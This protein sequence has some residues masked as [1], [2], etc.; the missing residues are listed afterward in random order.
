MT[1]GLFRARTLR[2]LLVLIG[3]TS[4]TPLAAQTLQ[5]RMG[6]PIDGLSPAELARFEEG[7]LRFEQFFTEADGLGPVFNDDSC[8]SCHSLP[9]TGGAGVL[10]VNRFGFADKGSPFDP[11]DSQGGTLLQA[12]SISEL[13]AETIPPI[14]NVTAQRITP[15][16][17]GAG[18][19]EAI[20]DT[21]LLALELTGGMAHLVQPL[22]DP[23]GPLRVGRFG[24]KSQVATI[25]TFSGDAALNEMGITNRLVTTENAP[26]GDAALLAMCDTVADPEDLP[27]GQGVEFIDRITDFQRFL[28]PP[29]QTPKTGM[30]G[31][32]VF[33]N[34]GC[35]DCHQPT[36]TTGTAPEAALSNRLIRPYSDFLVHNMGALGD[37]IVDGAANEQ[38]M[39]T[40]SLW[41]VRTRRPL[42]H[43]GRVDA[44]DLETAIDESVGWHSGEGAASAAAY[45]A[46]NATDK[47]ALIAFLDSLGKPEFDMN[48]DGAV[49]Q[50][51]IAGF[52]ACFTGPGGTLTPDDPCSVSDIDQDG[53]VD[54]DDYAFFEQAF[55][56]TIDDCDSNGTADVID[57]INGALDCNS[58]GSPD[59]CDIANLLS[60]DVNSNGIPDECEVFN[61]ERG[62]CNADGSRDLSDGITIVNVLFI[63][64]PTPGCMDACDTNDD[65]GFDVGDAVYVLSY[66]FGGGAAPPAPNGSCDVDP[67]GDALSC[68]D[69]APCP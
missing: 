49:A 66:L 6:D 47:A 10:F 63:G 44:A 68:I 52:V 61:F 36:F 5:P 19:V 56:G 35:A 24:W 38:Q 25:L 11:L 20:P 13:C 12:L 22:E 37:G 15:S 48:G 40:A 14:A 51:D 27:D 65:G 32:T 28:A 39:R 54:L 60:L 1:T 7:K 53:D 33:S 4:L 8:S 43:D 21:D 2:A 18:L 45:A 16:I 29:P 42:L 3:V 30:S 55:I 41:G 31:E 62:D 46:L 58:N 64:A 57:L 67:T 17:F 34:I 59:S 69:H 9:A 26:N 50:Q 23:T